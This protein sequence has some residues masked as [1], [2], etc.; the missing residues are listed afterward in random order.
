MLVRYFESFKIV[1]NKAKLV[2]FKD[3][4]R[5]IIRKFIE[6]LIENLWNNVNELAMEV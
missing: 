6:N 5:I 2:K 1:K 4:K 3:F